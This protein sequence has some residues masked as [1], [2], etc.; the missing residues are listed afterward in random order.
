M[1]VVIAMVGSSVADTQFAVRFSSPAELY[2]WEDAHPEIEVFT[3]APLVTKREAL[4][5]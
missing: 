3:M 2:A 4:R 5:A 1:S